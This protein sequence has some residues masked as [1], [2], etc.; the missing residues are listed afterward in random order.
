MKTSD[1]RALHAL[2]IR[3]GLPI[4]YLQFRRELRRAFRPVAQSKVSFRTKLL[5]G[6]MAA[7]RDPPVTDIRNRT[8]SHKANP[9]NQAGGT[10]T[11]EA[12]I[13]TNSDT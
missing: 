3:E 10:K 2:Y 12:R 7:R 5:L 8:M 4:S 13:A 1:K 11:T 9:R 6:I